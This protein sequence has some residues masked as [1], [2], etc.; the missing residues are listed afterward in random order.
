MYYIIILWDHRPICGPSLTE[1]S[2]CGAW[3]YFVALNLWGPAAAGTYCTY[4]GAEGTQSYDRHDTAHS[5]D[6]QG[7]EK[8][9]VF[10]A[11]AVSS[12]EF[13]QLHGTATRPAVGRRSQCK[14][15]HTADS[16]RFY[17]PHTEWQEDVIMSVGLNSSTE[18]VQREIESSNRQV[19]NSEKIKN[20][21]KLFCRIGSGNSQFLVCSSPL[22]WR[23]NC[24]L[25]ICK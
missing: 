11:V 22:C 13:L 7:V 15:K 14:D 17:K 6:Q 3:L 24:Q 10:Q 9:R 21:Y 5:G 8:Q 12:V 25:H 2:L 18:K 23:Y 4:S 19:Q 16:Y 20:C 1:T